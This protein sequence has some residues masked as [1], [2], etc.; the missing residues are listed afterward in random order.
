MNMKNESKQI[1]KYFKFISNIN[2]QAT[3]SKPTYKFMVAYDTD[4]KEKFKNYVDVH[5]R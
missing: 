2:Q 1:C 5:L 4:V 3:E